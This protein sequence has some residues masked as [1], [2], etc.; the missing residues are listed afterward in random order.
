MFDVARIRGRLGRRAAF[1]RSFLYMLVSYR[2]VSG[3]IKRLKDFLL[4]LNKW[5]ASSRAVPVRELTNKYCYVK[6]TKYNYAN[7]KVCVDR[8][9]VG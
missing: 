1:P 3:L 8:G 2:I 4:P 6:S 7:D 5:Q 9:H